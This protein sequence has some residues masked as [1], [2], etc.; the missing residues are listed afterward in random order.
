MAD[1]WCYDG[2]QGILAIEKVNNM[3]GPRYGNRN[4]VIPLMIASGVIV[5]M[6]LFYKTP[7]S[8]ALFAFF[9]LAAINYQITQFLIPPFWRI[10]Y[11]VSVV[12]MLGFI[13]L[14]ALTAIFKDI[15]LF[16]AIF[17]WPT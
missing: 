14:L 15:T 13:I 3:A 6:L 1:K 2:C 12:G 8:L 17:L 4:M 11:R 16:R 10:P 7:L 9:L 5:P